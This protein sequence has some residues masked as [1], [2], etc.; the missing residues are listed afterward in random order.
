MEPVAPRMEME[1]MVTGFRGKDA[2]SRSQ[3]TPQS[4]VD[5]IE[6][7]AMAGYQ[8]SGVF[9]SGFALHPAFEE[10]ACL[11]NCRNQCSVYRCLGNQPSL[12]RSARHCRRTRETHVPTKGSG[13]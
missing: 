4:G 6:Q 8:R 5:A 7:P 1:R 9:H 2:Q 3:T 12:K 10:I 13:P 11:R